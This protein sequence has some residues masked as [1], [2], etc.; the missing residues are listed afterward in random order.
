[1]KLGGKSL[2]GEQADT[3]TGNLFWLIGRYQKKWLEV[4]MTFGHQIALK[5]G[6]DSSVEE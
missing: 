4:T 6:K 1:M 5:F 2:E 3:G